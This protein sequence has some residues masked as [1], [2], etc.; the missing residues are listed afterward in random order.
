V[1]HQA[2]LSRQF[3]HS[4]RTQHGIICPDCK[5]EVAHTC[6]P[7][8]SQY[9]YQASSTLCNP[10]GF[11]SHFASPTAQGEHIVAQSI[12]IH[13]QYHCSNDNSL[14]GKRDLHHTD[15]ECEPER[16]ESPTEFTRG[17]KKS[18]S[19]ELTSPLSIPRYLQ[20]TPSVDHM[21]CL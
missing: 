15:L 21:L 9:K 17:E 8:L 14:L 19:A 2:T 10:A 5:Q 6:P 16:E 13:S 12:P 3:F 4:L 11:Q 18:K 1:L 20:P 7:A